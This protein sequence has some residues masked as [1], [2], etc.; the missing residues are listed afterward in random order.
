[1]LE[2]SPA[3]RKEQADFRNVDVKNRFASMLRKQKNVEQFSL[4]A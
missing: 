2:D 1:M 4:I 3:R